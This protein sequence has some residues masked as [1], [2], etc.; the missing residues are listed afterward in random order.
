[1]QFLALC[2]QNC[3][4]AKI[5]EQHKNQEIENFAAHSG[6]VLRECPTVGIFVVKF[7]RFLK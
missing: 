3:A 2:R 4:P 5:A 6:R 1:M 7:V